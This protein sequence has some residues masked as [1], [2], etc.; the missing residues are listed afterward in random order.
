M[1]VAAGHS[2]HPVDFRFSRDAGF[3][4]W[5]FALFHKG[6]IIITSRGQHISV[7]AYDVHCIKPD[8]PYQTQ[9]NPG[10]RFWQGDWILG[11]PRPE[12][13][14]LMQWPEIMPGVLHIN[15]ARSKHRE[16]IKTDFHNAVLACQSDSP[17]AQTRALHAL[18]GV[19][20]DCQGIDYSASALDPRIIKAI[21]ILSSN[22]DHYLDVELIAQ[23]VGYS[24]SRFAHVFREQV[25]TSPMSYR[26]GARLR[27]AKQLLLGTN[28]TV[29][30]IASS[31]FYESPFHFSKRFKQRMGCAP[32]H[33]RQRMHEPGFL[34]TLPST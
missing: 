14:D 27:Q 5:T 7:Q 25:G 15:I 2:N 6:S 11:E 19:L 9:I 24:P 3:P 20:L 28:L 26:E 32:T 31:L 21:E 17:H 10:C 1:L 33:F 13:I 23:R 29:Q 12:W 22:F 18:E 30:E 8:T 16:Q 34:A 4:Y